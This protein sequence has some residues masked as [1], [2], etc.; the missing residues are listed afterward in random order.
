ML[1]KIQLLRF[2]FAEKPNLPL[3]LALKS[4]W[5]RLDESQMEI[6]VDYALG[7]DM[8]NNNCPLQNVVFTTKVAEPGAQIFV[9]HSEPQAK[10]VSLDFEV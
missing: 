3:P 6:C 4:R 7:M 2:E 1:S 5:R 10:L 9:V 8:A